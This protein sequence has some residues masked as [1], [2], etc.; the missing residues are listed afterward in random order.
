M[1]RDD[2]VI[3]G[4]VM[5]GHSLVH[6]YEP[7]IPVLVTVWSNQFGVSA[8]TMGVVVLGLAEG[9]PAITVALLIWGRPPASTTPSGWR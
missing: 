3:V 1:N 6:S 9:S 4:L 8:A 5:L 2:R 7:S